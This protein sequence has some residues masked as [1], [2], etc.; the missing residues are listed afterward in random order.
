M[1]GKILRIL[2]VLAIV[3]LLVTSQ[4]MPVSAAT[5]QDVTITATPSYISI[6]IDDN[7]F[8]LNEE[9]GDSTIDADTIY[10]SNPL[11][12]TSSPSSP[13]VDGEC[14]FSITN[15]STVNIDL[16][17]DMEDFSGGDANMTNSETGS[18]GA[19]SYGAY[20]Y[21][22]GLNP[23]SNKV[24][25]KTNGTGSDTLWSSSSPGDDIKIG[26]ELETQSNAFAGGNPSTS[27]M[28]VTATK[29]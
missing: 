23:Y 17:V 25:I 9:T 4:V 24:I 8:T 19:T 14:H 10:Y 6:T 27:T 11:G 22:S 20:S 13:V 21:Y 3:S 18:N 26:F 2:T 16:T 7:T 1:K 28:K 15:D 12:D 29:S 5:Y